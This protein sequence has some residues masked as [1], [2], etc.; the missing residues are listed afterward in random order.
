[1][2]Q[3]TASVPMSYTIFKD[4]RGTHVERKD[5]NW[6]D[7][8]Q[9]LKS[10]PE[11]LS[12][13][14]CPLLKLA[15]FGNVRTGQG[16]LRTNTN[17]L[18]ISGVEGDYDGEKVSPEEAA[19]NL[20]AAYVEAVFYTTPSHTPE[21]PRWRVLAPLSQAY[22]P[23]ERERFVKRLNGALGGVLNVESFTQSQ[24][25]Y[26]GRI[27]GVEYEFHSVHGLPLDHP[28]LLLPSIGKGHTDPAAQSSAESLPVQAE[29]Q[30]SDEELIRKIQT[31]EDFHH[32]LLILSAR[33]RNRGMAKD[34]IIQTLQGLMK[35]HQ[36]RSQRWQDRYDD[37]PRM[38]D[39]AFE[40][41]PPNRGW[42]I[43]HGRGD[44]RALT[45]VGNV[46]RLKK[47]VGDGARF[48]PEIRHWLLWNGRWTGD[49]GNA[50]ITQSAKEI[51]KTLYHEAQT[52]LAASEGDD[53]KKVVDWALKSQ[54]SAMLDSTITLLSREPALRV[55]VISLDADPL[56]VGF[57]G[58][59]Q[60]IDL[61][62]GKARPASPDDLVTKSL[63]VSELGDAAQ[64]FAWHRF[65]HDVF[66]SDQELIAW[67]QR[68]CGYLLTGKTFEQCLQFL[69]GTGKNG[70]SVFISTLMAVLGDYAKATPSESLV[71][72]KRDPQSA[73]PDLARLVGARLVTSVETEGGQV[74]AESLIKSLTGGDRIV[75]R[76]LHKDLFEF[77]PS[78][79]LMIAGNHKPLIRGTDTGIWR[80][81]HLVPFTRMF[82]DHEADP[83][84][85]AKLR[86]ELPHI[87]AWM[88]VGCEA[89]QRD[90]LGKPPRRVLDAT[91]E[92]RVAMDT[93]GEF[94]ADRCVLAADAF[95]AT[96]RL[97]ISF[98]CWSKT[99]G[100]RPPT[101]QGF[102]RKIAER[103]GITACKRGAVRGYAGVRLNEVDGLELIRR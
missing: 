45:E 12:K 52:L 58:G 36:D 15:T 65:L 102:G 40:K 92:Y 53:A 11:Y 55:S 97:F 66:E 98:E 49:D 13:K 8:I 48:V 77:D 74:L 22:P 91:L 101:K 20:R 14:S 87:L 32:T 39:G 90:G 23:S 9:M 94:L 73:S 35:S 4:V 51:L 44:I 63:G 61:L 31:G 16:C 5:G 81:I 85:Q 62:T 95:V 17:M 43:R 69:Y 41:L 83:L 79:K 96:E 99:C 50:R 78:F 59:R 103:P 3:P 25:F 80:R 6:R 93:I 89:W 67:M 33:Y 27:S 29:V 34:A 100:L 72:S 82:S 71:I 28:D 18:T 46:D 68:W 70:K 26:Y 47:L 30:V 7:L 2:T 56:L 54:T 1:M 42:G 84:M 19:A 86:A 60:V 75:A 64:A 57:D 37:I 38:V 24:S 21:K 76:Y 10:P 88:L